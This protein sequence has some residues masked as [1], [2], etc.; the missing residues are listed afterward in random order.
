M[1]RFFL[2]E[3]G[4]RAIVGAGTVVLANVALGDTVAGV[5]ARSIQRR[6]T[7]IR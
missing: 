2:I 1:H 6:A 4:E 5:P 3:V 7:S